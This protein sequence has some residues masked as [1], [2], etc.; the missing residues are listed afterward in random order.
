MR[1]LMGTRSSL[2]VACIGWKCGGKRRECGGEAAGGEM[3]EGG[4]VVQ[5]SW[6][7]VGSTRQPVGTISSL[8]RGRV[9]QEWGGKRRKAASWS[10]ADRQQRA[11]MDVLNVPWAGKQWWQNNRPGPYKHRG[12]KRTAPGGGKGHLEPALGAHRPGRRREAAEAAGGEI[13]GAGRTGI[14][15][16]KEQGWGL[17]GYMATAWCVP[18]AGIGQAA[19]GK[20]ARSWQEEK[21][22]DANNNKQR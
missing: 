17:W 5:A 21:R 4:G 22:L 19:A 13:I 7:L 14:M 16:A 3:L 18:T 12:A 15:A 10:Q 8:P 11:G 1:A 9:G 20:W 2:R 6:G